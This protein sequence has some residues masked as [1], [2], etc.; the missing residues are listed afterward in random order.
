MTN[1]PQHGTPEAYDGDECRSGF[2]NYPARASSRR[3][4]IVE[5]PV[6][7]GTFNAAHGWRVIDTEPTT[8]E[9]RT[10]ATTSRSHAR[11]WARELNAR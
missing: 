5:P 7:G 6:W 8:P 1:S 10:I 4:Y 2:R 3:R 9:F 11:R